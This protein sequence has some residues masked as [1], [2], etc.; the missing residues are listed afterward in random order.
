MKTS[1]ERSALRFGLVTAGHRF[2]LRAL[3][4]RD[5]DTELA[6]RA[7]VEEAATCTL[8][9]P[10]RDAVL[11]RCLR[12]LDRHTGTRVPTLVERYLSS[13]GDPRNSVDRFAACVRDVLRYQGVGDP[14]IQQAVAI[15][16]KRYNDPNLTQR[17]VAVAVGTSPTTFSVQFRRS[18]G[19]TFSTFLRQH[20]LDRA[21]SL[22]ATTNRTIKEV[23]A[24]VGYNH[25][26]NF[27]HDFKRRFGETPREF[28]VRTI[29]TEAEQHH[30]RAEA[31]PASSQPDRQAGAKTLLV[32][33]DDETMRQT[34]GTVLRLNGYD[35]SFASGGAEGLRQAVDT[36]PDGILLDYRMADMDGLSFL[37]ELRQRKPHSIR[38][39]VFTADWDIY[40]REVEIWSLDAIIASKLCDLEEV[41]RLAAYLVS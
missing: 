37:R 31:P 24:S 19:L 7:F 18:I 28:R 13:G 10:E 9:E 40:D 5:P 34:I 21:A 36:S 4:F 1:E 6:L 17:D 39:A 12:V 30:E 16:D 27:D 32:I 23:W 33:D 14:K 2:L 20:R 35:V 22:L 38:V 15:I 29:R 25:A 11:L 41:E 8:P 3:P 26:A